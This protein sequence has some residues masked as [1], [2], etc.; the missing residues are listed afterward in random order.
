MYFS[1]LDIG[2]TRRDKLRFLR[3]YFRRPLREILRDE[4]GLLAWMER[5]AEK[6]YERKA[7]LRRPALMAG[8]TLEPDYRHLAADFGS[9]D[10]VFALEGERLTRDP[11]SGS[12]PHRAR[13]RALPRQALPQ[14]R[15]G[16]RRYLARPR[17]KAEWQNLKRFE[18]WGIPTAEV[19]AWG[20]ERKAGAFQ[21]GAMITRELPG[22]EDL[23]VLACNR[24]PAPE[25]PALGGRR[26]AGRSP[27]LRA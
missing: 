6:L 11:L 13:R 27:R 25:G 1:A 8:W 7:A 18:K 22:T 3:T 17:I 19:V 9:L 15:Q 12:H 26:P 14:R 24:D 10:S 16:L 4:A 20:L 23:S 21:R 5:K 2:L